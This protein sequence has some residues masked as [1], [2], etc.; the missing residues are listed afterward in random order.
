MHRVEENRRGNGL[1]IDAVLRRDYRLC[2]RDA[3]PEKNGIVG[4][5]AR[6]VNVYDLIC[7]HG[8]GL[9]RKVQAFLLMGRRGVDKL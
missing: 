3:A 5:D 4:P 9:G 1:S 6:I 8:S 2:A 7:Q